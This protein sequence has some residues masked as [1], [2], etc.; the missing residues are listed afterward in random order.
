[1]FGIHLFPSSGRHH[2]SN[3]ISR[4]YTNASHGHDSSIRW[5][6]HC[7][8]A[9]KTLGVREMHFPFE[10]IQSTMRSLV[11]DGLVGWKPEIRG[12]SL[13]TGAIIDDRYRIEDCLRRDG[14]RSVYTVRRIRDEEFC[15][16]YC[17]EVEQ[18]YGLSRDECGTTPGEKIFQMEAFPGQMDLGLIRKLLEI[19]HP[20]IAHVLEVFSIGPATYVISEHT[21]GVTLDRL[22]GMLT[23]AQI[24]TVG[25]YLTETVEFLHGQGISH[26]SLQPHNLKLLR[27]RPRLISLSAS[28][29][30]TNLAQAD[31]ERSD[32]EDFRRL[33]ETLEKLA[34]EYVGQNEGDLLCHLLIAF[35]EMIERDRLSAR[36]VRDALSLM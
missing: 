18:T 5:H 8:M 31:L 13:V 34:A 21:R 4:C 25:I 26:M 35:E 2:N 23:A 28:R 7:S 16:S 36:D 33:V 9:Q 11:Q 22:E 1:M 20:G 32:W 3:L 24:R 10:Q 12:D 29:L 6:G 15:Q 27:D 19:S 30:R 14:T 17:R